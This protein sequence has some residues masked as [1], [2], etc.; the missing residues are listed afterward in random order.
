MHCDSKTKQLSYFRTR[1]ARRG[2][3][4]VVLFPVFPQEFCHS[5]EHADLKFLQHWGNGNALRCGV[6]VM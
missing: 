2:G 3:V 4:E 1:D 5:T 6:E